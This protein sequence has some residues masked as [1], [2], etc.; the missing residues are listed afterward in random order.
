MFTLWI[1]ADAC[2]AAIQP[3]ILRAT[4]RLKLKAVFV[5]NKP[6]NMGTSPY[7]ETV[8]VGL[9][10]D[11]ADHYIVEHVQ[12]GDLVVTQD[13]P[14]A[15]QLVPMGLLVLNPHGVVFTPANI[16]ER[17]ATRNL[18]TDLRD[19]G[20]ITGGPK[21]FDPKAKEKFANAL[22]KALTQL[23]KKHQG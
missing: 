1:D 13:I 8:Q 16:G 5:A 7:I 17:L 19:T 20:M 23:L 11:V 4:S 18:M 14:L 3:I 9:G 10:A 12:A 6:L 15:G 22:D 21:P 2:P